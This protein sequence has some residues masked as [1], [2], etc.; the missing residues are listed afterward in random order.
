MLKTISKKMNPKKNNH[1]IRLLS[2]VA[3]LLIAFVISAVI[4]SLG[5]RQN[6]TTK[7]E[8]KLP[9]PNTISRSSSDIMKDML[10]ENITKSITDKQKSDILRVMKSRNS[11]TKEPTTEQKAVILEA[12][13][14]AQK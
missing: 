5:F 13:K 3:L 1:T 10:A 4:T 9:I 2:L 14:Q 7:T 8:Q 11:S 6:N 12:M